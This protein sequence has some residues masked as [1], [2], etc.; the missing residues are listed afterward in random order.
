M[1][2]RL[3]VISVFL[4]LCVCFLLNGCA[5]PASPERILDEFL[6]RYSPLP[7]GHRYETRAASYEEEYLP[8][9]LLAALYAEEDGD[10]IFFEAV[11][12]AS[13]Y[14]GESR[15]EPFEIAVLRCRGSGYTEEV[16]E[17]CR[18]RASLFSRLSGSEPI[19]LYRGDTVILLLGADERGESL[20][21]SI[22]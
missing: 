16:L 10:E 17:M 22:L 11:E 14:L 19:L 3:Y 4:L 9:E 15:T 6:S 12:Q 1:T 18:R 7:A 21:K 5:G 2:K 8:P 20:L 13:L